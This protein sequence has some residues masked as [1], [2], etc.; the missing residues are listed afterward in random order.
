MGIK[1]FIKTFKELNMVAAIT[2][3]VDFSTIITGLGV[4]FGAVALVLVAMRGGKML[5]GAVK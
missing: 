4:V 5:L 2:G 1:Y 3:A